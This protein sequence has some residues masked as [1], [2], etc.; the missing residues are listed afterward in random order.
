MYKQLQLIYPSKTF[1]KYIFK[2]CRVILMETVE[3]CQWK[4]AENDGPFYQDP[5]KQIS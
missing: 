4:T 5:R 2:G 1:T 3:K